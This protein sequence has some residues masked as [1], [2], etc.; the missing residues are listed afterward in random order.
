MLLFLVFYGR[1][2]EHWIGIKAG[3]FTST[4]MLPQIIKTFKEKKQRIFFW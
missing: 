2:Y 1:G 3:A 4:A